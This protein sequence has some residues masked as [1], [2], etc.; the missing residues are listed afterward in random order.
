MNLVIDAGNT[1]IKAGIFD[2]N[3][4]VAK[5]KFNS[6]KKN[7]IAQWICKYNIDKSLLASVSLSSNQI[8]KFLPKKVHISIFSYKTKLPV[9]NLYTT[10]QTLGGDRI[11]A[12]VG[13]NFLYPKQNNLIIDAGTCLTFDFINKN[14]EYVGGSISPGIEMRLKSLHNFTQKL[15]LIKVNEN[16]ELIGKSTN[17][18][19]L[20]GV[21]NGIIEEVTGMVKNYESKFLKINLSNPSINL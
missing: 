3:E 15:P 20:S 8:K 14:G 18:S 19:I 11:T 1:F 13:A 12:V 4:L 21:Q 5:K 17:E 10:P 2:K 9:K 16:T 7:S 6:H